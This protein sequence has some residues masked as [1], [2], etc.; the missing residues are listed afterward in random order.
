M[1]D[2]QSGEIDTTPVVF[3]CI[4]HLFQ[5]GQI[6]AAELA[7]TNGSAWCLLNSEINRILQLPDV[8]EGWARS[9]RR[10]SAAP[11]G[12]S[13][14]TSSAKSR[15]GRRSSRTRACGWSDKREGIPCLARAVELEYVEP[16]S[17]VD[18]INHAARVDVHIVGLR[19]RLTMQGL[20][21][22]VA[23]FLRR[24]RIGDIHDA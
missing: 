3:H 14:I 22:E 6:G 10:S 16:G 7:T 17:A 1:S 23:D 11:R 13:P 24:R 8:R 15:N 18:E 5:G 9:A 20:G 21:N 2:F 19:T 12:N 4:V